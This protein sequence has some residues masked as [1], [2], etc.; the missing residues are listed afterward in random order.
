[1][2]KEE[3]YMKKLILQVAL[4]AL[5]NKSK[6]TKYSMGDNTVYCTDGV[7]ENMAVCST[8][9][10]ASVNVYEDSIILEFEDVKSDSIHLT[11]NGPEI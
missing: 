5:S 9:D 3:C 6:T 2:Y 8:N 4:L 11:V 10:L 1:M 7:V